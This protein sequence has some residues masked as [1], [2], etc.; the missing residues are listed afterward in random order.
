MREAIALNPA[1]EQYH[2]NLATILQNQHRTEDAIRSYQQALMVNPNYFKAIHGLATAYHKNGELEA[3]L[4]CFDQVIDQNPE[5]PGVRFNKAILL[6]ER[7]EYRDTIRLL[8]ET[9]V[10]EPETLG[11]HLYIGKAHL[12]LN[13]YGNAIFNFEAHLKADPG[14]LPAILGLGEALLKS[15]NHSQ[16]LKYFQKVISIKKNYPQAHNNLAICYQSLRNLTSAQASYQNA[17]S[18]DPGNAIYHNNYGTL[19]LMMDLLDEAVSSF[20]KALF[21]R[22]DYLDAMVN[23]GNAHM[24]AKNFDTAEKL[25]NKALS[26]SPH[27][28]YALWHRALL[29]LLLGHYLE[30]FQDYEVRENCDFL[31]LEKRLFDALRWK[32]DSHPESSILVYC[33]QGF[34]DSI[35][36]SRFLKPLEDL[37]KD[38]YLECPPQLVRIFNTILPQDKVFAR[39]KKLPRFDYVCPLH[40]LP[41]FLGTTVEN[42]PSS[43]N[44]YLKPPLP[45]SLSE[46]ATSLIESLEKNPN[47]LIGIVWAGNPHQTNDL[48][49][50]LTLDYFLKIKSLRGIQLVSM[51]KELTASENNLLIEN[52]I[53]SLGVHAADFGDTALILNK[54]DLL[55]TIDTAAGHL[56]GALGL[57]TWILLSYAAD[58]RWMED[59][60]DSP[61]YP[62]VRLFRQSSPG[63]WDSAFE[64]LVKAL[65][66]LTSKELA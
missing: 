53:P 21:I 33:E 9:M 18:M 44:S 38:V 19:L 58:W 27:Q 45:P 57:Q 14:S 60:I 15:D 31:K 23:L 24:N 46:E 56:S 7:G 34:G 62:F 52:Q 48:R 65:E 13:D 64:K 49:R 26:Q 11:T 22:P 66:R 10:A 51:Q 59:R 41:H 37:F 16:A 12:E 36:F 55:I 5:H 63:N 50:S 43:S 1:C 29:R 2:H 61:W 4:S 40:S 35:Q 39:G 17:V 42:I 28:N 20:E 3:A 30:G 25:F 8:M 47:F 32:G 54:L 6:F